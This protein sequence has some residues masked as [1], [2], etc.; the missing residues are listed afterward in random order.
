[1]LIGNVTDA[2][3]AGHCNCDRAATEN[4]I[5]VESTCACGSRPASKVHSFF[6]FRALLSMPTHLVL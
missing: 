3:P 4:V 1:M 6:L 5:P 2:R